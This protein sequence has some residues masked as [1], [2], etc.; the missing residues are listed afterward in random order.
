LQTAPVAQVVPQAPQ[1]SGSFPL[2][3]TH[4]PFGHIVVPPLQLVA[5]LPPL[6]TWPD[7]QA[8]PQP[9]QLALSC[10]MQLPLQLSRPAWHWQDPLWQVCPAVQALPHAPQFCGSDA[11][12]THCEPQAVC[13]EPQVGCPPVGLP[14]LTCP[15]QP[16][17]GAV[18]SAIASAAKIERFEVFIATT[19]RTEQSAARAG[20]GSPLV[21]QAGLNCI[22]LLRK[23]D[24]ALHF[25]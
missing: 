11:A 18:S 4:E 12:F 14:P 2:V 5:Q 3:F 22:K 16:I 6:Q 1:L 8:L 25:R 10:V 9:P 23:I 24:S 15:L 19:F 17:I 13:P 7:G 20:L 21:S